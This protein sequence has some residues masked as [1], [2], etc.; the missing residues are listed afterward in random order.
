MTSPRIDWQKREGHPLMRQP[1]K[2][3]DCGRYHLKSEACVIPVNCVNCGSPAG[4][5]LPENADYAEC[6]GCIAERNR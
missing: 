1:E 3:E 6:F 4:L 5:R 2:C